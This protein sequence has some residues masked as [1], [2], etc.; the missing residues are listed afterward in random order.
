MH[1]KKSGRI[2]TN[3]SKGITCGYRELSIFTLYSPALP[4][5]FLIKKH[6]L[7][8]DQKINGKKKVSLVNSNELTHKKIV[9]KQYFLEK[10]ITHVI[11]LIS[12][13]NG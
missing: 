11:T 5:F 13:W 1:G 6:V 10:K 2:Y 8:L 4:Y 7:I 9:I 3:L 12:H